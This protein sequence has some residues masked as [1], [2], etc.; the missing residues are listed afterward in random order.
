MASKSGTSRLN[1]PFD[2][3]F[4]TFRHVYILIFIARYTSTWR[5]PQKRDRDFRPLS[6]IAC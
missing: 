4:D 1:T 6:G 5:L 2:C 3:D